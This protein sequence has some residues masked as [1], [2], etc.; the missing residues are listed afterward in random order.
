LL[1]RADGTD[2]TTLTHSTAPVVALAWTTAAKVEFATA[3]AV[4][5]V[6]TT[7]AVQ[8]LSSPQGTVAAL[9]PDGSVAYLT[10]SGGSP[11]RV[12][13]FA[14][15]KGQ[16]LT[17][18]GATVAFSG[19]SSTLAWVDGSSSPA[20]LLTT[21]LANGSISSVSVLDPGSQLGA[22][23]LSQ[24]GREVAYTETLA[25]GTSKLV[26]ADLPTG[27][28]LATG[29]AASV[30]AFSPQAN[31]LALLQGGQVGLAQIPGAA[32]T[33]GPLVPA[34]AS[35][36]LHAFLDAQVRGDHSALSALSVP[37]LNT[38][39]LLP[40]GISRASLID[41]VAQSDGTVHGIATLVLDPS[42]TRLTTLVSD[43]TLTV[44]PRGGSYV[45]SS[46]NASQLHPLAAGPH[47]IS[48]NTSHQHG[49]LS[50][51]VAFDSDLAPASLPGTVS[52]QQPSG[53]TVPA[54]VT[55]DANSR[56]VTVTVNDAPSGALSVVVSTALRDINGGSLAAPF[57]APIT[58][59]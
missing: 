6:T 20:R 47:V 7:G 10:P 36:V 45:V 57:T 42:L 12:F 15:G 30:L 35:Q 34:A 27:A 26:L 49:N 53:A 38:S 52:V 19:D 14:T 31:A 5:T 39:G 24:D 40:S 51:Q 23:A 2:R 59:G 41:S 55:Y 1:S 50:V 32:S 25:D 3:Q 18:A 9:S 29:S 16:S 48:V 43:E 22:I 54:T 11:G 58:G 46:L 21:P 56:T 44:S 17:G 28:P 37:G 33:S 8:T 13:T 4:R